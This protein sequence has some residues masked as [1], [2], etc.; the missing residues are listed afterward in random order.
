MF[1]G[2]RA[3]LLKHYELVNTLRES[4]SW[5]IAAARGGCARTRGPAKGDSLQISA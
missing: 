4:S 5:T 3:D 2:L 1:R